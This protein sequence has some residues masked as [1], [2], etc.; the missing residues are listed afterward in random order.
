MKRNKV[1]EVSFVGELI[2]WLA[3]N[4]RKTIDNRVSEANDSG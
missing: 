2:G 3:V 1:D 4:P